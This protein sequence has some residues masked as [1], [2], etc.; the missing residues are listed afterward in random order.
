MVRLVSEKRSSWNS[1]CHWRTIPS[2]PLLSTTWIAPM[3]YILAVASSCIVIW[4]HPSPSMLITTA[5]GRPTLAPIAAGTPKPMVPRPPDVSH[6]RGRSICRYWAAVHARLE[7]LGQ[8][9]HHQLQRAHDRDLGGPVLVDLGRVDVHVDDLGAGR[10]RV[11]LAGHAVV[12]ARAAGDQ[13]V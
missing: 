13:Q 4:K 7:R 10:E 9:R 11:Q 5:S 12:E 1:S 8:L 3:P 6:R 2:Q